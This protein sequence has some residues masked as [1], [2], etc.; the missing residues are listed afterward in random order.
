M[1]SNIDVGL[2]SAVGD[3]EY[4]EAVEGAIATARRNFEPEIIIYIA[5]SDPYRN[6][7]L[8]SLE[9]SAE[10]MR[11][12]DERVARFARDCG[13]ALVVLPAGGYSAES[14]RIAATGF[15]AIA[16]GQSR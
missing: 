10:G 6:D 14:P 13:C 12:R 1:R 16:R 15:G 4:L 3:D 5:G 9:V 7:P 11:R 2:R 8:G